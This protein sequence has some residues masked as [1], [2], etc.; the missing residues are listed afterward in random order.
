MFCLCIPSHS[1]G[2]SL[3]AE[4]RRSSG[5]QVELESETQK[6]QELLA[7]LAECTEQKQNLAADLHSLQQAREI[8]AEVRLLLP[9]FFCILLVI[10]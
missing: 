8:D 6:R 2:G 7:S 5:L 1:C 9:L 3:Q 4:R 10:Y